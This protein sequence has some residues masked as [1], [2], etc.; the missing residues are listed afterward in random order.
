MLE[1]VSRR[2][3]ESVMRKETAESDKKGNLD[4]IEQ[5]HM[6]THTQHILT[7]N[8]THRRLFFSSAF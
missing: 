8:F 1:E 2:R 3:E 6:L 7:S 4:N 5:E